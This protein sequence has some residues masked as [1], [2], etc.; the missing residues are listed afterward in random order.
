[1]LTVKKGSLVK[2]YGYN[3]WRPAGSLST[4]L[5][6][7][8]SWGL[9]EI[10]VLDISRAG[11]IDPNVLGQIQSSQILTPIAY[12]GG[13]RHVSDVLQLLKHG[14]DRFVIESLYW[15]N[16]RLLLEIAEHVGEQALIASVPVFINYDGA[17]AVRACYEND[18]RGSYSEEGLDHVLTKLQQAPVSELFVTDIKGEGHHGRFSLSC[19]IL[20]SFSSYS[21]GVIWFGG[22][23][24]ERA[25]ALL[26]HNVTVGVAFGNIAHEKELALFDVRNQI[27]KAATE[28]PVRRVY[29]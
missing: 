9:D 3:S 8:D 16:E 1:M 24:A 10:I 28:R 18:Y 11:G 5:R 27:S 12:G 2:S 7:L 6:N 15:N 23:S 29:L 21:K 14:C 17:A 19:E 26:Q 22:L 13:I 4:G 20:D 25:G